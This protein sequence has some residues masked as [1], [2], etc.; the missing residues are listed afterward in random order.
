VILE[1]PVVH[2]TETVRAVFL[3]AAVDG[4]VDV[5]R[6]AVRGQWVAM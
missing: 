5:F 6:A 4:A 3:V 2:V 1:P